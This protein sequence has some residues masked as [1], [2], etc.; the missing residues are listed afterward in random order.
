MS[1]NFNSL[2]DDNI[3]NRMFDEFIKLTAATTVQN[4]DVNGSISRTIEDMIPTNTSLRVGSGRS[5]VH[6]DFTPN[7]F[8]Y[9]QL[10]DSFIKFEVTHTPTV[11]AAAGSNTSLF[12]TYWVG[13]RRSKHLFSGRE[14]KIGGSVIHTTQNCFAESR[15]LD[16]DDYPTIHPDD[17]VDAKLEKI[18]K[19]KSREGFLGNYVSEGSSSAKTFTGKIP[20]SSFP[21]FKQMKVLP[22]FFGLAGVSLTVSE[23]GL[24]YI[25]IANNAALVQDTIKTALGA[26]IKHELRTMFGWHQIGNSFTALKHLTASAYTVSDHIVTVSS[27]TFSVK[28]IQVEKTQVKVMEQKYMEMLAAGSNGLIIPFET[29]VNAD[30]CTVE[31]Y[32]SAG[33]KSMKNVSKNL[34]HPGVVSGSII[35]KKT[36]ET[37]VATS[38]FSSLQDL[39]LTIQGKQVYPGNYGLNYG[40]NSV[41]ES[42]VRNKG[43]LPIQEVVNSC[44]DNLNTASTTLI[45]ICEHN[46]D[47]FIGNMNDLIIPFS[48]KNSYMSG[49]FANNAQTQLSFTP[50]VAA[51]GANVSYDIEFIGTINNLYTVQLKS[52]DS[53]LNQSV[54]SGLPVL[55]GF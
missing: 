52:V 51:S 29:T 4:Q 8:S 50:T 13:L 24:S 5:E 7:S 16:D 21:L 2:K 3:T 18:L 35:I 36:G 38:P 6:C 34:D 40:D 9:T 31:T 55:G 11:T 26:K 12:N 20:L 1:E 49:L 25:P 46:R 41:F 22:R 15:K 10:E 42:F 45:Q 48:S 39:K 28:N 47:Y 23:K 17:E 32:T 27:S 33:V 44:D 37:T 30:L 14:I 43:V 53:P 54:V 19:G